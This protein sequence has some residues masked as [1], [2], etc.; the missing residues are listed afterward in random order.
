[1]SHRKAALVSASDQSDVDLNP[2]LD[3]VFILLIFFIVTASFVKEQGLAM[4]PPA[5]PRTDSSTLPSL[6]F[7][8][9]ENDDI[10]LDGRRIDSAALRALIAQRAAA[11]DGSL[12]VSVR[13]H[14]RASA[15]SYVS[16]LDAARQNHIPNVGLQL[17][18][19]TL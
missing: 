17:Y 14:E 4:E 5:P 13:A 19:D 9:T 12:G 1:M 6:G 3:V 10:L 18:A 7:T 8:V 16:I 15:Y 2:M 11:A